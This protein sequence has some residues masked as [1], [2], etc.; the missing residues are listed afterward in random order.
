[1]IINYLIIFKLIDSIIILIIPII[2][3]NIDLMSS[4]KVNIII[5]SIILHLQL[6]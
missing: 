2:V 5:V 3:V 6:L 1:M 4:I